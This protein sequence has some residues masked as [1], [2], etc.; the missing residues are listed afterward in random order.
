MRTWRCAC[1]IETPE[2]TLEGPATPV[3]DR[4]R[5]ETMRPTKGSAEFTKVYAEIERRV[6]ELAGRLAEDLGAPDR[7]E[8][9]WI[10]PAELVRRVRP[11][12]SD[13]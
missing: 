3:P 8:P 2:I 6:E 9:Q 1:S 5:G 12:L 7:R 10:S 4:G 13:N 11:F